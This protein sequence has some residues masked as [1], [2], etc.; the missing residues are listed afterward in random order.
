MNITYLIYALIIFALGAAG[1]FFY[2]KKSKDQFDFRK[3]KP[4][5]EAEEQMYWKLVQALPQH[6]I[7]TKISL[8]RILSSSTVE[9]RGSIT[10]KTLDFL[11]CEKDFTLVAAIDIE[12]K[13]PSGS[14]KRAEEAKKFALDKAGIKLIKWKSSALPTDAEILS[15]VLGIKPKAPALKIVPSESFNTESGAAG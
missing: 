11:V 3:K 12:D 15:R 2:S 5:T 4:L 10:Q 6:V 1:W 14:R 13:S 9:A 7:L 8:P